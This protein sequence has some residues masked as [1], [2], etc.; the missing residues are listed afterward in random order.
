MHLMPRQKAREIAY[1]WHSVITWNDPGAQLYAFAS[2]GKVQS[3]KHR[4]DCLE[5]LRTRQPITP[6]DAAE[7]HRLRRYIEHVPLEA[8]A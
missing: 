8:A 6:L 4:A 7:L 3:E 1:N 5:Y 2:T